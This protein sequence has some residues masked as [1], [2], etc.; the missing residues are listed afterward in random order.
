MLQVRQAFAARPAEYEQRLLR[1]GAPVESAAQ[2]AWQAGWEAYHQGLYDTAFQRWDA[3]DTR[4]PR[5]VLVPQV[6]YWQ[7]RA[8]ALAGQD[9]LAM[10]L[11]RRLINDFPEHYYHHL[12]LRSQRQ[13]PQ[14]ESAGGSLRTRPRAYRGPR[15]AYRQPWQ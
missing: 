3:F 14:A 9:A 15:R 7:A 2:R 13:V 6:L 1:S 4:F 11:Y 5:T 10:R 8:A 12:A